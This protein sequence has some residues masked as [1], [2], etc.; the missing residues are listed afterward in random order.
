MKT[1]LAID[2]GRSKCGVAVVR[3]AVELPRNVE[4]LHKSVI[5]SARLGETVIELCRRY[6]PDVI[7]IGNGTTSAQAAKTISEVDLCP[8]EMVDEK[9][10]SVLARKRFF[11]DNPPRGLKRLIPISLQTPD[12]PCDD[13]V[14]VILAER[15][16]EGFTLKL[17]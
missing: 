1:I 7:I 15:Y 11:K 5:E 3:A 12:R 10:T 16:I 8:I 13:Y 14:A 17:P 2:P 4:I 9:F 6:D